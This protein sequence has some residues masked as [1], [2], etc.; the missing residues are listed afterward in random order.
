MLI[1]NAVNFMF[2]YFT[3]NYVSIKIKMNLLLLL[4]LLTI[5]NFITRYIVKYCYDEEQISQDKNINFKHGNTLMVVH[6]YIISYVLQHVYERFE[7][8]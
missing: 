5:Y 6:F 1:E 2:C 4:N 8:P 3:L 7:L